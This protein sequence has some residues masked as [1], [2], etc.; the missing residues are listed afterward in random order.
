MLSAQGME[1]LFRYAYGERLLGHLDMF[2]G[3]FYRQKSSPGQTYKK[4]PYAPWLRSMIVMLFF[5]A[6]SP[7]MQRVYREIAPFLELQ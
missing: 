7:S 2:W 1:E 4:Q 5:S 3:S 6:S